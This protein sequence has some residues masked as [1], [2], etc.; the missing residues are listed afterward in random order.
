MDLENMLRACDRQRIETAAKLE[1]A[2]KRLTED[3]EALLEAVNE[4]V[5]LLKQGL[6]LVG[7]VCSR[8]GLTG[9]EDARRAKDAIRPV[10]VRARII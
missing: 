5:G 4:A 3:Q 7:K 9:E 1:K 8:F 10:R 2:E 6:D